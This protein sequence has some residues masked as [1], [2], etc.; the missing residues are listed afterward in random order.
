M[1]LIQIDS[2]RE[3]EERD[4]SIEFI[5]DG[6]FYN[7]GELDGMCWMSRMTLEDYY[8]NSDAWEEVERWNLEGSP[9]LNFKFLGGKRRR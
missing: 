4:G 7:I 1:K 5:M 2:L 6:Y 8:N 3:F 9:V